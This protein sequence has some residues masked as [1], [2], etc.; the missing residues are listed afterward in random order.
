MMMM[1]MVMMNPSV[2]VRHRILLLVGL[3]VDFILN[4]VQTQ[5]DQPQEIVKHGACQALLC[6]P[7]ILIC[8]LVN[9]FTRDFINQ[10]Y[11]I[12]EKYQICALQCQ[13]FR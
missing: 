12:F 3:L 13:V 7:M 8:N 11:I 6:L 1:V 5:L 10:I 9:T 4:K 2:V